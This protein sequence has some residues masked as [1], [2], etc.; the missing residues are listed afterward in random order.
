MGECDDMVIR[1]TPSFKARV[2]LSMP[3]FLIQD[4]WHAVIRN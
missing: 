2:I 3:L 1:I 4:M